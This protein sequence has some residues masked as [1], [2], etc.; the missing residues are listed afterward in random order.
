[1][2]RYRGRHYR[3]HSQ[4]QRD[5]KPLKIKGYLPDLEGKALMMTVAGASATYVTVVT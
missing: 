4:R 1:M 2:S 5:R 3:T